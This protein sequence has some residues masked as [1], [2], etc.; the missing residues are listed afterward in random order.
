MT[1]PMVLI[2]FPSIFVAL[3]DIRSQES[4]I[5]NLLVHAR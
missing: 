3:I 1:N 2:V 4:I 5:K